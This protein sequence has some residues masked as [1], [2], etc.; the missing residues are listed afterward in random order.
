M[1]TK[2]SISLDTSAGIQYIGESGI[3]HSC[4]EAIVRLLQFGDKID[5]AKLL[6]FSNSHC[7]LL[8]VN[9][10]ES[11]A[12]KSGFSSGYVGEGPSA[13]SVSLALLERH[14]AEI[15]EYEV[16]KLIIEKI[17]H[18]CL[19]ISD[20]EE[21]NL[22]RPIRPQR[23]YDYILER[24]DYRLNGN[25]HLNDEFPNVMPFAILDVRLTD[26]ALQF[27]E[28]PDNSIH[29]SGRTKLTS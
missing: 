14:G 25:L 26:L 8:N 21:I 19:S 18:S 23:W 5:G 20:L 2:K 15:K 3:S 9:Y 22:S 7:F 1:V 4:K 10:D 6:S 28:Q 13:L 17:D 27:K 16:S 24:H 29:V 12:I 11:V